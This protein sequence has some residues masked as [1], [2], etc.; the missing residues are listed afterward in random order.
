MGDSFVGSA[1]CYDDEMKKVRY[2]DMMRDDI[3]EFVSLSGCETLNYMIARAQ[4]CEIDLQH[5]RKRKPVQ[6]K[7]SVAQ[8]KRT[9]T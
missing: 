3:K 1:V 5:L 6:I 9:R 8:V 7:I 4:E 2:H